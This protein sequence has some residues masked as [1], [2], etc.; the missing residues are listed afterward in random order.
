MRNARFLFVRMYSTWGRSAQ[1]VGRRRPLQQ[2]FQLCVAAGI[3][4]CAGQVVEKQREALNSSGCL[5]P[6]LSQASMR[7]GQKS[8][9]SSWNSPHGLEERR[10][11]CGETARL[12]L[13]LQNVLCGQ[14]SV[15]SGFF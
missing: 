9:D 4:L 11:W 2:W 5:L 6:I 3:T 14:Q 8:S 10:T 15:A 7:L 13:S 12:L 1:P